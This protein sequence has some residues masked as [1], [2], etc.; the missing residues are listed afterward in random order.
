MT[1]TLWEAGDAAVGQIEYSTDLFDNHTIARMLRHFEVLL[2]GIID[3]PYRRLSELPL[4]TNE[5]VAQLRAW[6]DTE[7]EYPAARSLAQLLEERAAQTPEAPA[8]LYGGETIA[9]GELNRRANRL[10]HHLHALGVGPEV[11][12]GVCLDRS[13]EAVVAILG[14]LKAGGAYL[15]LDP[16]YP[17]ARLRYMLD[18]AHVAVLLTDR[19]HASAFDFDGPVVRVDSDRLHRGASRVES[20]LASRP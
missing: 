15:P 18:D 16:R 4:L 13:V 8:F 14:V 6:N 2:E 19:A 20:S 1:V 9:Y 17:L 3:D 5:D 10:A 12:V 11:L 7:H